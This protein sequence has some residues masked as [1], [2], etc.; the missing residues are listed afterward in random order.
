VLR[1]R[2]HGRDLARFQQVTL[3]PPGCIGQGG[4]RKCRVEG[5]VY[6]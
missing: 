1:D 5:G 3:A 2:Q 4:T 6:Y